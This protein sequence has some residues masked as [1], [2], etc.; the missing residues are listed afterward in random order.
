MRRRRQEVPYRTVWDARKENLNG[1][2]IPYTLQ[3]LRQYSTMV[4]DSEELRESF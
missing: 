1:D 4:Y 2:C 3:E